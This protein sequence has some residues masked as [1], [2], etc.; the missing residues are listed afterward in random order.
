MKRVL[1]TK[2]YNEEQY[3]KWC[4]DVEEWKSNGHREIIPQICLYFF[5]GQR[6][7][8]RTG[9]VCRTERG[10][11][12]FRTKREAV[13]KFCDSVEHNQVLSF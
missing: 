10:A 9:Y 13:K 12:W 2:E 4:D 3:K 8:R 7:Q 1:S 11:Y 5:Y 6:G